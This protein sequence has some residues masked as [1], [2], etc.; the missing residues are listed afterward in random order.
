MNRAVNI[1]LKLGLSAP[2]P[3]RIKVVIASRISFSAGARFFS[4]ERGTRRTGIRVRHSVPGC[5]A[6]H[7]QTA[8]APP[9]DIPRSGKRSTPLNRIDDRLGGR[10]P[11]HQARPCQR[12]SRT[13]QL[14]SRV[15]A[16]ER[17]L[18]RQSAKEHGAQIGLSQSYSRWFIQFRP[19]SPGSARCLKSRRQGAP[20]RALGNI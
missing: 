18:A 17:V 5:R 9:W 20:H 4:A 6:P 12:P 13:C 2:H 3:R 16:N 11:R 8:T 10:S 7:R 15:V 1:C 14:L 19:T